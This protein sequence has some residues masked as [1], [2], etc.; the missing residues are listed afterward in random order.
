MNSG[1]SEIVRDVERAIQSGAVVSASV[2]RNWMKIP[3]IEVQGVLTDLLLEHSQRINPPLSMEE[4]CGSVE[5]YYRECLIQN[6]QG[7]D[8]VG[9]RH[10]AGYELVRWF[11]SLWQ[12]PAVPREY[13]TR[14]KAMLRGLYVQKK[15]PADEITTAVLEHLFETKGIQDFFA[16]WKSD[17]TLVE[18]FA[19]AKSWGDEHIEHGTIDSG[20]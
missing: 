13:L 11:R 10:I 9:S 8:H 12:D 7:N 5:C 17:P 20:Q 6:V 3:S 16:D 15:V 2:V 14:L 19:Q 18:A 1:T 4:I